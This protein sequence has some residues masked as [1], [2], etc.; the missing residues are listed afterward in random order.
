MRMECSERGPEPWLKTWQGLDVP[1][2]PV[3]KTLHSQWR[4]NGFDPQ[5]AQQVKK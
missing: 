1:G 3:V 2:G 4:E 5:V